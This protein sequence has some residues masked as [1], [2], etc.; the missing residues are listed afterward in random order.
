MHGTLLL[1]VVIL[2]ITVTKTGG[3]LL[4]CPTDGSREQILRLC[5]GDIVQCGTRTPDNFES[6]TMTKIKSRTGILS[7]VDRQVT[8]QGKDR[9]NLPCRFREC[10]MDFVCPDQPEDDLVDS[11]DQ[12]L[13][14]V[15]GQRRKRNVQGQLGNDHNI[16][17]RTHK[18]LFAPESVVCYPVMSVTE[19]FTPTPVMDPSLYIRGY[20]DIPPAENITFTYSDGRGPPVTCLN[21]TGS[22][23][24]GYPQCWNGTGF[25]CAKVDVPVNQ[26]CLTKQFNYSCLHDSNTGITSCQS[27]DTCVEVRQGTQMTCSA[28]YHSQT[29][30][31]RHYDLSRSGKRIS[32][33]LGAGSP[34]LLR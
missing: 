33:R 24:D 8:L 27:V 16:F 28:L 30:A 15:T 34:K 12:S 32:P 19:L 1:G 23:K 6:W 21:T 25:G 13:E 26:T 4:S 22:G 11:K 29:F 31:L 14:S 7:Q 10:E 2:L 20:N 5:T 18:I 9:W 17:L 3:R